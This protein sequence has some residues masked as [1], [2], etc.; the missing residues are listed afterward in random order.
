MHIYGGE[1]AFYYNIYMKRDDS[2]VGHSWTSATREAGVPVDSR[3]YNVEVEM[4]KGQTVSVFVD[5][6]ETGIHYDTASTLEG[7]LIEVF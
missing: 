7:H 3:K 4:E 5:T 1:G 6:M 2:I